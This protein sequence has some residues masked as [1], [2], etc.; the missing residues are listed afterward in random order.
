M[1]RKPV[2]FLDRPSREANH[3]PRFVMSASY[4]RGR[5]RHKRPQQHDPD[6]TRDV[7]ES[8]KRELTQKP[9]PHEI[10]EDH[11][12]DLSHSST[13]FASAA[14]H[15][16]RCLAVGIWFVTNVNDAAEKNN[17]PSTPPKP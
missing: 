10:G 9:R 2:A 14:A 12:A 15:A 3:G 4:G 13:H 16:A 11:R 6:P 5:K 1:G 7:S 8:D 17:L